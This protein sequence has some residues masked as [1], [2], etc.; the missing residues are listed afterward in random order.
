MNHRKVLLHALS[1]A[2][3][4][5]VPALGCNTLLGNEEGTS[6]VV[7]P[8]ASVPATPE[9]GGAPADAGG[10]VCDTTQGNKVCFGLC[11]KIDQPNTGCGGTSCAACDPK[12]VVA[13]ACKGGAETLACGYDGC[14]PGFESCDGQLANGCE[15]SLGLK[16]S[17]GTC[18]TMCDGATPFCAAAMNGVFGCVASCP[19]GTTDCSGSCVDKNTSTE[20]CG[21]C[22]LKC[23]RV[24]ATAACV[25]GQCVFTCTGGTHAC[26]SVCASDIDP[27]F[28][29]ASCTDC[30]APGPNTVP[31]CAAGA[32][33]IQCASGYIDCDANL[34]NGC[35]GA[36]NICPLPPVGSCGGME[37]AKGDQC[38]NDACISEEEPCVKPASF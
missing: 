7:V 24:S 21:Q 3:F 35:E 38:C 15:T 32:C 34:S 31:T 18:T 23:E 19:L 14:R 12:N 10:A 9:G 5:V 6:R 4:A 13:T 29:G 27:K 25:Q 1:L 30:P 22:G 28:C 8:D 20:N 2:V 11:V 17:C 37:C 16:G 36:S 26:G 33:G